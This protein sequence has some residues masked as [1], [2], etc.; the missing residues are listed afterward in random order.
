M[1]TIKI[2]E[3]PHWHRWVVLVSLLLTL[4]RKEGRMKEAL[5]RHNR[6]FSLKIC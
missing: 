4:N 2:P 1:L 3:R 5:L 6:G